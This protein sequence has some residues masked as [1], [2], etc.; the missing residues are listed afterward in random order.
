MTVALTV[1]ALLI[2]FGLYRICQTPGGPIGL[3]PA[4]FSFLTR[5]ER[6]PFA[7][8]QREG[9][10]KFTGLVMKYRSIDESIDVQK[11]FVPTINGDVPVTVYKP[12]GEGPFPV[13]L[14]MHGGCWLVGRP[15]HGESE[16][17]AIARDAGVL[18]VSVDYR[19]APE[20]PFP[21]GLDD[22]YEVLRWLS[23]HAETFTGDPTRICTGGNSAGGNLAAAVALRA[24]NE[25][26][27]SLFCQYLQVPVLDALN[28][29]DWESYR[30]FHKNYLL[31][32]DGMKEAIELYTP[33]VEVRSHEYVS[34]VRANNLSDLPPALITTAEVDVLRDE[35]ET[36]ARRLS[37]TGSVVSH[38]RIP[39]TI[40]SFIG[41]KKA[42]QRSTE[43]AIEWIKKYAAQPA[44]IKNT[45]AKPTL[46]TTEV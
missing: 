46:E 36:Y 21:A 24:R 3:K 17:R 34:P 19:L 14:W 16:L 44:A 40:H 41:S 27:I 8:D 10:D 43:L 37:E 15:E 18:V 45:Q 35:A 30:L 11:R 31:T 5:A 38:E 1:L 39:K 4:L 12:E 7:P 33:D 42:M 6:K 32:E 29:K 23:E 25:G 20:H 9:A 2:L 13:M 26:D 22:C 28:S